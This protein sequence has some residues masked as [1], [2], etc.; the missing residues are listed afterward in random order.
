MLV[1]LF[2]AGFARRKKQLFLLGVWYAAVLAYLLLHRHVASSMPFRTQSRYFLYLTPL[3][4]IL[5][6]CALLYG[7]TVLTRKAGWSR[8][9]RDLALAG[10]LLA[11]CVP[12]L[13]A[14]RLALFR[15][16]LTN[17]YLIYDDARLARLIQEEVAAQG[18][19]SF[20]PDRLVIRGAV[21]TL[22]TKMPWKPPVDY[23]R[24]GHDNLRRLLG[25]A[26]GD[27]R[28]RAV[29]INEAS[30]A[31]P[32]TAVY[33]IEEERVLDPKG[34]SIEPFSRTMSDALSRMREGKDPE[35]AALFKEAVRQRPFL[36]NHM[37]GPHL[38]LSDLGWITDGGDFRGLLGRVDV[39]HRR[40][41]VGP[42][43]KSL[44]TSRL[45][46]RELSNYVLCLFCLSALERR[47]GREGPSRF[48]LSQIGFIERDPERLSDWLGGMQEVR[49]D[50]SLSAFAERVGDPA[51]F[52]EPW[53]W[54]KEDYAF[55]RFL[56]RLVFHRD[57]RSEWDRRSDLVP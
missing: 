49:S 52:E 39:R 54:K 46:R 31:G 25:E 20:S 29:R 44:R 13:L 51:S 27:R 1:G 48:W 42:Q 7:L 43:Q 36:L 9:G 38:R 23:A 33:R 34:R 53:A 55:G 15:G 37:L 35:A 45:V 16:R 12:N 18:D 6:S 8:R 21:P 2:V 41:G 32:G 10:L 17:T 28:M 30:P 5:F 47:A 4:A 24:I 11:L 19:A 26:F 57:L 22:F 56:V 50:A 40:W 14:I 3:F